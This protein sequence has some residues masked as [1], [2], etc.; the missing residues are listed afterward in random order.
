MPW[1]HLPAYIPYSG[2][3]SDSAV[4]GKPGQRWRSLEYLCLAGNRFTFAKVLQKFLHGLKSSLDGDLSNHAV[5][6]GINKGAKSICDGLRARYNHHC[7]LSS[8]WIAHETEEE[9]VSHL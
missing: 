5:V 6:V 4:A 8:S 9:L 7:V 2:C 3:E 1:L